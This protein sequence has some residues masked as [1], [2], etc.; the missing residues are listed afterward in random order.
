MILGRAAK[1]EAADWSAPAADEEEDEA[2]ETDEAV[3]ARREEKLG[4][5]NEP[6]IELWMRCAGAAIMAILCYYYGLIRVVV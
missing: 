5:P 1:E 3:E 4:P 2:E 6:W